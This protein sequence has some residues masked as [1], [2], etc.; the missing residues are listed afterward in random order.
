MRAASALAGD[1]GLGSHS[2]DWMDVSIAEMSKTGLHCSFRMSRQMEPSA[3]T[4]G[5]NTLVMN[6]T[7]GAT[8]GYL[9]HAP[10]ARVHVCRFVRAYVRAGNAT[11]A[12]KREWQNHGTNHQ[13]HHAGTTILMRVKSPPRDRRHF[14]SQGCALPVHRDAQRWNVR[15]KTATYSSV[16]VKESVNVP[17]SHT[18]PAGP[19]MM[20]CHWKMSLPTGVPLMPSG[21]SV[22]RVMKSFFS[23]RLADEVTPFDD[24]PEDDCREAGAQD[25]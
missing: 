5:W 25:S 21:G 14:A 11:A 16:N 20:A 18:V 2:S 19:K 13:E 7:L 23:R 3:Y 22:F 10:C 6:L 17:P 12:K 8:L 24:E 1:L 15:V 9:L 4:F